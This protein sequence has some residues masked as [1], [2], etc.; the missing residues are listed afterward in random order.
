[1]FFGTDTAHALALM[2]GGTERLRINANG[3]IQITPEGSTSNPYALIDTSGDSV[4]F[5][6]KKSSGNN[7]FRFLT[8]S[9]GTV[10]ERLRID[11]TGRVLI[12]TVADETRVGDSKLQVY[13]SDNKHPAI[14]TDSSGSNGYTMFGDAYKSDESQVNIGISYSSASLVLSRGVK[15]S[16]TADNTYLS[17]QDTYAN[18]PSALVLGS[19][20]ELRYHTTETSA[21]TTT[22]SAVSLTEV[23]QI[24]R[25]GNIYQKI[26]NRYMFFGASSTLK[27]G[28]VSSD[29]VID[30]TSGHLQLKKNGST[31]CTVR[32]DHLQMYG[33]IKMNSGK[34]IDFSA[35]T[36]SSAS[37]VTV[38]DETL[39]H[40]E[41]GIWTPTQ[42]TLGSWKS[43]AEIDGKYQR[44]GNW[45]TASFIVQ[46]PSN[47]SGHTASIDG[48][49]YVN[50]NSGNSYKQGGCVNY[51]NSSNVSSLLIENGGSRI[52]LYNSSG[53]TINLTNMDNVEVRGTVIYRVS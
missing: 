43:G 19:T 9:S 11:S 37:G 38:H 6:A 47:G 24:D 3:S 49:P 20:G 31:I 2:S 5:N 18:R 35:Q 12:G 44:V 41:E 51:S 32:D 13:T 14:R 27:I 23:F 21:T 1:M 48:L 52:Y 15:V 33:D 7:E 40:F 34:G 8:Q 30:A 26:T 42:A 17:S 39:D 28:I 22:D 53:S 36:A 46:Y 29:P 45:V 16:D 50:N 4:R 25:V 10:Q